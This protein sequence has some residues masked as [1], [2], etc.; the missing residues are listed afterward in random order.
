MELLED[1]YIDLG[2]GTSPQRFIA[3]TA[4]AGALLYT[5]KHPYFFNP[6]GT[7]KAFS[8]TGE[9]KGTPFTWWVTAILTGAAAGIFI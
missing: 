5:L 1:A 2:L 9:S 8:I 6:D 4:V 3:T 7:A